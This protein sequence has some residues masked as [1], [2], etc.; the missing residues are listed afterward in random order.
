MVILLILSYVSQQIM[1]SQY[2]EI[3]SHL[4]EK[5]NLEISRMTEQFENFLK[6]QMNV[7]YQTSVLFE[8]KVV[9]L[10]RE[11]LLKTLKSLVKRNNSVQ[12]A[13]F[14]YAP[15]KAPGQDYFGI[16]AGKGKKETYH[17]D[18]YT[19]QKWYRHS[20]IRPEGN[21]IYKNVF[22]P[23]VRLVRNEVLIY[24][25]R[26]FYSEGELVGIFRLNVPLNRIYDIL[27]VNYEYRIYLLDKQSKYLFSPR[28]EKVGKDFVEILSGVKH[29]PS[30]ELIYSIIQEKSGSGI[31]IE[32]DTPHWLSA[33]IIPSLN[34]K[35]ILFKNISPLINSIETMVLKSLGIV[36][37]SL[38]LGMAVLFLINLT[39]KKQFVMIYRTI[40]YLRWGVLFPHFEKRKQNFLRDEVGDILKF[41]FELVHKLDDVLEQ[42]Y[43]NKEDTKK[44][45]MQLSQS[46]NSLR[47]IHEDQGTALGRE[48]DFLKS[49]REKVLSNEKTIRKT[50]KEL[51]NYFLLA[52]E[53][54]LS[55]METK[56]F[57][58]EILNISR[59][60]E[61]I[62][63]IISDVVSQ[64]NLLAL[65][66]SV[67]AARAGS[68]GRGFAVVA[69]E[70]R[71]L[72]NETGQSALYINELISNT[73][74]RIEE[75][76]EKVTHSEKDSREI[77]E[78]LQTIRKQTKE[79]HDIFQEQEQE[80]S[81]MDRVISQ[82]YD[83][84]VNIHK[85]VRNLVDISQNID[86]V[87]TR[88]EKS[89][90]F[91]KLQR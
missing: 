5:S 15:G 51:D 11:H 55:M 27:R 61:S 53:N 17:D 78:Q 79:M 41:L 38:F 44:I 13:A 54:Q 16:Q 75:I 64:T 59:K 7:L 67:E 36:F 40:H 84:N 19:Y 4:K 29:T 22:I 18:R 76:D 73:L 60:I 32:N 6:M 34:W 77:V 8:E 70:I 91:F 43:D 65:N 52:K 39:F 25:T 89:L 33:D 58:D 24:L 82:I 57:V 90:E 20:L 2:R 63:D 47:K 88:T 56:Q 10:N 74:S 50:E 1:G 71:K 3:V 45:I 14:F 87:F 28:M 9:S 68:A 81:T 12:T 30:R 48:M 46:S 23:E 85:M 83:S 62:A 69:L 66:A 26:P 21:E 49:F 35:I 72:S 42:V 86:E 37:F 80:I 31:F